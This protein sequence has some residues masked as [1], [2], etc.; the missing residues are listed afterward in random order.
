MVKNVRQVRKSFH[1]P[2][3]YIFSDKNNFKNITN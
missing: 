3:F 1:N 2:I